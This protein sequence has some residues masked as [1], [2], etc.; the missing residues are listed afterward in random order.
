MQAAMSVS[1]SDEARLLSTW[2][3]VLESHAR[4]SSA[5]EHA[6]SE[7]GLGPSEYEILERLVT[8]ECEHLRMQELA[9]K[10]HLSQSALSRAVARL[11]DDGL[12]ERKM[13]A[14]DRRGIYVGLTK[15]GRARHKAARPT[16][17][18]VLTELLAA[19]A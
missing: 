3:S 2:H 6:L 4:V 15:A 17:R 14:E 11:E 18:R 12:V 8:S 1:A 16:H 9:E 19:S 10:L 5:L 7:H 13:C